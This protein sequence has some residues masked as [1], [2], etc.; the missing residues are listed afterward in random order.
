MQTIFSYDTRKY[1]CV[2]FVSLCIAY[3]ESSGSN[4][5]NTH[6]CVAGESSRES[7]TSP[8]RE[9]NEID[10]QNVYLMALT[11]S[12]IDTDFFLSLRTLLTKVLTARQHAFLT[13]TLK[14]GDSSQTLEQNP[15]FSLCLCPSLLPL[16]TDDTNHFTL[17]STS[18]FCHFEPQNSLTKGCR[19][20][21]RKRR[22]QY[23]VIPCLVTC[24]DCF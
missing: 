3:K 20:R 5:H 10:K 1:V 12:L 16:C 14:L 19:L 11:Q 21:G 23:C 17:F 15:L 6:R 8:Q 7:I 18:V 22:V 2:L 4:R 9:E 24:T 13:I